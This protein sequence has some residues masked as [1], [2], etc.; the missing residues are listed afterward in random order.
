MPCYEPPLEHEVRYE[1]FLAAAL[2]FLSKRVPQYEL[3]A[4]PGLSKWRQRHDYI[5][6]HGSSRGYEP[7][8]YETPEF[9]RQ[10]MAAFP[11]K[12]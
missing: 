11:N 7:G 1:E 3:D 8:G 10:F 4:F 5:D 9:M 2:C 12:S 6:T